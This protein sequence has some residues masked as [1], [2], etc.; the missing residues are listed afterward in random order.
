M[1]AWF[2]LELELKSLLHIILILCLLPLSYI[3]SCTYV[4]TLK[5]F[6]SF[7]VQQRAGDGGLEN[8]NVSVKNCYYI[9]SVAGHLF[10]R[11]SMSMCDGEM[12]RKELQDNCYKH[13]LPY[14]YKTLITVYQ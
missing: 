11:V 13:V 6:C 7:V 3:S 8:I 1:S 12:V 4:L 14:H 2:A 5:Y 9:G 10:S